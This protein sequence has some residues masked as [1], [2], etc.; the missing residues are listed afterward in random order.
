MTATQIPRDELL[1]RLAELIEVFEPL[2]P[3]S[4]DVPGCTHCAAELPAAA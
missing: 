3:E 1:V 4:C 2:F